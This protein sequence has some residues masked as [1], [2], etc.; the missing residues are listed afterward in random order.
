M[1]ILLFLI[2]I[3]LVVADEY[4]PWYG[5]GKLNSIIFISKKKSLF[6]IERKI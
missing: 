6:M 2:A 1:R 5:N 4:N 3:G